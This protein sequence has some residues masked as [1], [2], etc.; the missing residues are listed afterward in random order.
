MMKYYSTLILV[1]IFSSSAYG[2]EAHTIDPKKINPIWIYVNQHDSKEFRDG[3]LK[4]DPTYYKETGHGVLVQAALFGYSDVVEKLATD[5]SLIIE[6]GNDALYWAASMGRINTIKVLLKKGVN[7]NA[8]VKNDL[9]PIYSA[10]ENGEIATACFLIK[11]GANVNHRSKLRFYSLMHF[12]LLT[13]NPDVPRLLIENGFTFNSKD[14]KE[15]AI[16]LAKNIDMQSTISLLT[17]MKKT[18]N[19][20]D[21]CVYLG[22]E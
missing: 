14:Q 3:L 1:V 15:S 19:K 16:R 7:V 5:K 10:V 17:H 9:T 2:R 12:A 21:I 6:Q 22:S 13:R 8:A 4:R 11:S 18:S 20:H